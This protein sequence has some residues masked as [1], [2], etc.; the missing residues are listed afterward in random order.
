MQQQQQQQHNVNA[1]VSSE[2][3]GCTFGAWGLTGEDDGAIRHNRDHESL[4]VD[5]AL[6]LGEVKVQHT[7]QDELR[8]VLLREGTFDVPNL[9]LYD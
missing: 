1:A 7:M 5:A 8:F 2:V 6:L 3:N 4:A 9:K